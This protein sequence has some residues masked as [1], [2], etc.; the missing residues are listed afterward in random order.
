MPKNPGE[1]SLLGIDPGSVVTGYS[2]LKIEVSGKIFLSDFGYLKMNSSHSLKSRVGRFGEFIEEKIEKFKIDEIALETSFFYKNPQVFLKLGYL[3]GA[4]YFIAHKKKLGIVEFSP[5]EVKKAIVG[6]GSATKE[7]VLLMIKHMFPS[8]SK[9]PR[10]NQ[11]DTSDAIGIGIC[12]AWK[13]IK[14]K[15]NHFEDEKYYQQNNF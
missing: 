5:K 10:L 8:I 9:D 3:R 2:V 15:Q 12:G 4:I 14:E 13:N 11:N 7:Q 6:V 1:F